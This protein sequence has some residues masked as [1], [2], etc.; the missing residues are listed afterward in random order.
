M[1]KKP[2]DEMKAQLTR[3]CEAARTALDDLAASHRDSDTLAIALLPFGDPVAWL[4]QAKSSPAT[5]KSAPKSRPAT[6][7]HK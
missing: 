4:E 2:T 6:A 3:L 5:R 1:E 7:K